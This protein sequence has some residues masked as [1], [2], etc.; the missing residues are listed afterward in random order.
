MAAA[1]AASIG[2]ALFLPTVR[3]PL[4]TLPALAVLFACLSTMLLRRI[5]VADEAARERLR[6]QDAIAR[7]HLQ[8]VAAERLDEMAMD[9]MTTLARVSEMAEQ[10]EALKAKIKSMEERTPREH[11]VLSLAALEPP[12]DDATLIRKFGVHEV[13]A[14]QQLHELVRGLLLQPYPQPK[15]GYQLSPKGRSYL[16]D[17]GLLR[18]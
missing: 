9:G 15:G 13:A 16:R 4:W 1:T 10:I 5:R 2:C 12:I 8:S 14:R 3:V 17:H 7:S 6:A 11:E 18:E